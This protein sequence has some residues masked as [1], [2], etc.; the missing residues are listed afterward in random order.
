MDMTERGVEKGKGERQYP[1]R[2]CFRI[3]ALKHGS[4]NPAGLVL[5]SQK[6]GF[7][8]GERTIEYVAYSLSAPVPFRSE[9]EARRNGHSAQLSETRP[10]HRTSRGRRLAT[11]DFIRPSNSIKETGYE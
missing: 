2:G 1:Y 8:N 10:F 7:R 11:T 9:C 6:K 4:S 5:V 3:S